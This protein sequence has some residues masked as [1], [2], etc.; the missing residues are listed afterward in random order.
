MP[1]YARVSISRDLLQTI[2]E[3]AKHVYPRETIFL[4]R[5]QRKK[6]AIIVTDLLVPPLASYGRGFAN[7]P[8]YMLPMDFSLVGTVHS[9]PSGNISPSNADLNHFFGIILMIVGPPFTGENNIAVYNRDAE[10][11]AVNITESQPSV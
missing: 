8:I 9:H 6:D 10:K 7:I 2:F 11:L 5:G 3:S 1:K 4:L